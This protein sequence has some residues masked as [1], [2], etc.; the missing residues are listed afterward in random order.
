MTQFSSVILE[1][2]SYLM[3]QFGSLTLEAMRY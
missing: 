3:T 2:L 1:A